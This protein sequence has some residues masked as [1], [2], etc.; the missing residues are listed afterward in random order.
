MRGS[1]TA[2]GSGELAAEPDGP[3]GNVSAS[4]G[5]LGQLS[6]SSGKK[7]CAPTPGLFRPTG[8]CSRGL[9]STEATDEASSGPL[10]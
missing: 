2:S 9:S 4:K 7:F 3:I 1:I 5:Q 6:Q 8:D 10:S